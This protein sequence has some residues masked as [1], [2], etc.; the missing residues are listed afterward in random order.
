M[1][2]MYCLH[3][4][5]VSNNLVCTLNKHIQYSAVVGL[6]LERKGHMTLNPLVHLYMDIHWHSGAD[7]YQPV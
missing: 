6:V 2:Y 5:N 7:M 4:L 1:I 3:C